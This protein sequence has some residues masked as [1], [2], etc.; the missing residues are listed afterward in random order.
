LWINLV[1]DGLPALALALEAP[2]RDLMRR[3]PRPVRLPVITP[4]RGF[5]ILFHG[6]I[7]ALALSFGFALARGEDP[8]P[9]EGAA[10][11]NEGESTALS[12][13]IGLDPRLDHAR[14]IAFCV[15]AFSQLF[16]S[17]A[18]RSQYTTLPELGF[19]SNPHLCIATAISAALQMGVVLLPFAQGVFKTVPL[20]VGEWLMV[21]G[22]A[23]VPV[24]VAESGKLL[25]RR[26]MPRSAYGTD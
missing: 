2:D 6:T 25:L 16:Y 7:M 1:T 3:P 20:S 18:C 21:L 11:G 13:D 19:V 24:T 10:A 17:Y 9:A 23:L 15:M 22:L 4:R 8:A 26:V 5:L 12:E 14:T